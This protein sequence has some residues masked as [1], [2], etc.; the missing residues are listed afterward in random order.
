MAMLTA[1]LLV[2]GRFSADQE[3]TAARANG[4]SLV[5]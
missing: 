3:L 2:F 1:C 4:I 5:A